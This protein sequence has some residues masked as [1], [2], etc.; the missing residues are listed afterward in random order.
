MALIVFA[1]FMDVTAQM[2]LLDTPVAPFAKQPLRHQN[3]P[4]EDVAAG[5]FAQDRSCVE[6]TARADTNQ[7]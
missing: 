2:I 7:L 5:T 3:V 1:N 4:R 6:F